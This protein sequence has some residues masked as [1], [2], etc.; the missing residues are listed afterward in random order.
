MIYRTYFGRLT[1]VQHW[2]KEFNNRL[3]RRIVWDLQ[4]EDR[5]IYD[6]LVDKINR[7][8]ERRARWE[9]RRKQRRRTTASP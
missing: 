1:Q 9:E 8:I 2:D 5:E 7:Q 6:D 4:A 3:A